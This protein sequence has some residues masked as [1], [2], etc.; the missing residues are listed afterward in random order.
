MAFV[1]F[2]PS[3][4]WLILVLWTV[5][6]SFWIL[7]GFK[8]IEVGSKGEILFLGERTKC[9]LEEGWRFIPLPFG[10]KTADGREAVVE[11]DEL[12]IIIADKG[13][14]VEVIIT[15]SVIRKITD[16]NKYFDVDPATIRD[17]LNDIWDETIRTKIADKSLEDVLKMHVKLKKHVHSTMKKKVP[18][19][20]GID[21]TQVN[22]AGITVDPEIKKALES[23][24]REELEREAQNV[25]LINFCKRVKELMAAGL[26]REQ[27]V[28]Q[29]QLTIGSAS[30]KS[31]ENKTFT[32]DST[33]A[34]IIATGLGKIL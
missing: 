22:I 33:T 23:K 17:G 8:K 3:L 6:F 19:H 10:I 27:A 11:L 1:E 18:D 13:D 16:P 30:A 26:S 20:W 21:V 29:V 9:V 14:D 34:G 25:E 4:P 31:I 5:G 24:K 2:S 28:E 7:N 15:G 12:K 32:L